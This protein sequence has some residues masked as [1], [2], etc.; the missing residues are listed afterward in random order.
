MGDIINKFKRVKID[1]IADID[2]IKKIHLRKKR[3]LH[4]FAKLCKKYNIDIYRIFQNIRKLEIYQVIS[5]KIF[6]FVNR[7]ILL[8]NY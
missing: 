2:Q 3:V 1:I 8:T 5:R 6:I 7:S 4:V